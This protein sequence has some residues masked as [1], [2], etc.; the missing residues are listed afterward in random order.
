MLIGIDIGGS[1]SRVAL[2]QKNSPKI[3][4]KIQFK[5]SGDFEIDFAKLCD[6]ITKISQKKK[7]SK[8]GVSI[9]GELNRSKSSLLVSPNLIDFVGR[10]IRKMLAQ[11]FACKIRLENDAVTTARGEAFFGAQIRENFLLVIWGSG[12]GGALAEFRNQK[13][14]F[15]N[16]EIGREDDLEKFCGGNWIPKKFGKNPQKLN[17]N[18]WREIEKKFASVLQ[19]IC[20]ER[21]ITQVVFSGGVA[22]HQK[23]HVR[24]IGKLI[25]AKIEFSKLC[26]NAGLVGAATL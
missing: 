19:K 25:S 2:F 23:I 9:A 7:I 26:E 13:F 14:C 18:E 5:N 21:K 24:A 4:Q 8:I 1:N 17:K 22:L 16:I 15:R 3:L 20:D 12:V 11:K 10:P 6:T